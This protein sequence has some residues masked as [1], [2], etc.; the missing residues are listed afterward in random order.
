MGIVA[1]GWWSRHPVVGV[2][3]VVM[4]VRVGTRVVVRVT[5]LPLLGGKGMDS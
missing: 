5:P 4:F 2:V 1:R 3:R